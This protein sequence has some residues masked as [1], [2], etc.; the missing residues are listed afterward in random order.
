MYSFVSVKI[1]Q[2][3]YFYLLKKQFRFIMFC[4]PRIPLS[5]ILWTLIH[6][7]L[8]RRRCSLRDNLTESHFDRQHGEDQ[9]GTLPKGTYRCEH[10][11]YCHFFNQLKDSLVI[12]PT[13]IWPRH[14]VNCET[15][16]IQ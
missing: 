7:L 9:C 8:F 14:F 4:S 3:S 16:G 15:R 10:C 1:L 6:T 13:S 11:D 5:N 12:G 2:L